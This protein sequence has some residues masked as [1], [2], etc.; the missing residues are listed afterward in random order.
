MSLAWVSMIGSAVSEPD[1]EVLVELGRALQQA[2]VQ[3]EHVARIGFAA[4][5]AAQQQAHLA[6]GDGLL[7]QVVVDDQRVHAV[8]AEPLAHRAAGEGRQELQRRRL[9]GG[10]GDNDGVIERAALLERVDDLRHGRALL[11][12]GD[13]D[14]VEL[15]RL[16][17]GGVNLLLVQDGVDRHGGL[18]GLAVADDQ[19]A[20]AATDRGQA[21]DALQPRVHRLVHRL[22]RDDAGRLHV[23]AAALGDIGQRALAVDRLA[24]RIDHAAQQALADRNVDDLGQAADFVALADRRGPRRRS[25]C[26]RCRARG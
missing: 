16:V 25:R 19:L 7:G 13:V 6:I 14:A 23:H 1:A 12:D 26:R 18:A 15:G 21:V 22:A 3:I 4:R 2:R 8:V 17:A 9:G 20:L 24:Q 5:R 10:G 11:T